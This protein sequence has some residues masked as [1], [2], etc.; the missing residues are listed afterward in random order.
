MSK[1]HV[2]AHARCMYSGGCTCRL[3]HVK[4]VVFGLVKR[5]GICIQLT[6]LPCMPGKACTVAGIVY[7]LCVCSRLC[8]HA[9]PS[10]KTCTVLYMASQWHAHR[11]TFWCCS[12]ALGGMKCAQADRHMRAMLSCAV[13]C[14]VQQLGNA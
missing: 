11:F 10:N 3:H 7:D 6:G 5:T 1:C 4:V 12:H 2:L 14:R 8:W 13:A 9:A